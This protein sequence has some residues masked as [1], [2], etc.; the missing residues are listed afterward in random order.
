MG[1]IIYLFQICL[2]IEYHFMKFKKINII[3]FKSL[4]KNDYS[5]FKA[6][7]SIALLSILNKTFKTIIITKFNI[8]AKMNNLLSSK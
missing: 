2:K 8:Y 1:K 6:Y 3:V 7:K 5:K 4:K